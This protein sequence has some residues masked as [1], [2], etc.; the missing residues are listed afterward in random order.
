MASLFGK[1]ISDSSGKMNIY[2]YKSI[3]H[4]NFRY[5]RISIQIL[6]IG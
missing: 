3:S 1:L 4:S 2:I 6:N 5:R